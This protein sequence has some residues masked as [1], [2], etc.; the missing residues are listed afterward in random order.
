M[1]R[2]PPWWNRSQIGLVLLLV[3]GGAAF[4]DL[5]LGEAVGAAVRADADGVIGAEA[6]FRDKGVV[7]L[8]AGKDGN[9]RVRR[10]VS[11]VVPAVVGQSQKVVAVFCV[12]ADDFLRRAF[13][14]ERVVWQ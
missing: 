8:H 5:V 6:A 14:S 13:P 3:F 9:A 2:L 7:K 4:K 11:E 10:K 12:E 1:V